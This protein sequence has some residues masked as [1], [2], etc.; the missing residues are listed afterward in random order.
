MT[1]RALA[2]VVSVACLA[3]CL[4]T[5]AQRRE[6]SLVREARTF[7]DDLRWG[8]YEQMATALPRDEGRLLLA[9]AAELGDDLVVGDFEVVSINFT[10]GGE[11]ANV[12]VKLEWYSKRATT[13]RASTLEQRWELKGTRWMVMKQRR[14][15]GDRFPLVPEPVTAPTPPTAGNSP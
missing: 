9:R 2:G 6:E 10:N 3:G 13:L 4:L 7:N 8:R 11:A 15:R 12:V 14:V 1:G 5:P